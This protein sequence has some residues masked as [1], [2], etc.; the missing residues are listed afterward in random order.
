MQSEFL[1]SDRKRLEYK[2]TRHPS[3]FKF[4]LAFLVILFGVWNSAYGQVAIPLWRLHSHILREE[5]A[6]S[7]YREIAGRLFFVAREK[8]FIIKQD[9]TIAEVKNVKGTF[10]DS[11]EIEK[12]LLITTS[13]GS[14]FVDVE[15]KSV[16]VSTELKPIVVAVASRDRVLAQTETGLFFITESGSPTKVTDVDGTVNQIIVIADRFWVG[17]DKGLFVIDEHHSATPIEGLRAPVLAIKGFGRAALVATPE[18]N[19]T[20]SSD[21][22]VTPINLAVVDEAVPIHE[23]LFFGTPNGIFIVTAS[24]SIL[25]V[26]GVKGTNFHIRQFGSRA[27]V[28][29]PEGLWFVSVSGDSQEISGFAGILTYIE[30]A[31]QR[32]FVGTGKGLFIVDE[33]GRTTPVTQIGCYVSFLKFE[34]NRV[35]VGTPCEGIWIVDPESLN[36]QRAFILLRQVYDIETAGAY[37]YIS[38]DQGIYRLDSNVQIKASLVPSNWWGKA[39]SHVL[40]S[41]WLPSDKVQARAYYSN[42]NGKDAYNGS[43]AGNFRF[44]EATGDAAPT[45]LNFSPEKDFYYQMSWGTTEARFWVKD[46]WENTFEQRETYYGFPSQYSIAVFPFLLSVAFV[47]SCFALAPRVR[48]CHTMLMNPWLRKYFSLG[49]IPMLLSVFPFLRRY[50]LRRYAQ[51]ITRD[52]ELGE[53]RTGLFILTKSYRR[54]L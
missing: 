19:F 45:Y 47:L 39:I 21:G 6:I 35:F 7:F 28:A 46:Q 18:T 38:S 16:P 29:S 14:W 30:V 26:N 8:L 2:R 40:P 12:K 49:S 36:L 41:K 42:P 48:F 44:L 17:T 33:D 51:S 54:L 25:H 15:G 31:G 32:S 4:I 3:P 9:G 5:D 10:V 37:S 20:V 50:L 1:I 34:E 23:H 52:K 43:V 11:E 22:K 53:W 13:Q 24:G 27:L